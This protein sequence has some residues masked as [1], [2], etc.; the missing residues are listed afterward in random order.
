MIQV[1]ICQKFKKK[2]LFRPHE[3]HVQC[4]SGGVFRRTLVAY[5]I[6]WAA[7]VFAPSMAK[8]R[9]K[10]LQQPFAYSSY[11][12]DYGRKTSA[13]FPGHSNSACPTEDVAKLRI[14]LQPTMS[15]CFNL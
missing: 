1:Y 9:A 6:L 7:L 11:S 14:F 4:G 2:R 10:G 13:L 3:K 8:L 15:S 12:L 5:K